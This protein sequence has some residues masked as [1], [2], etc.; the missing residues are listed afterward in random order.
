MGWGGGIGL[1]TSV[2][3]YLGIKLN[4]DLDN[5]VE[6]LICL[7]VNLLSKCTLFSV[8]CSCRMTEPESKREKMGFLYKDWQKNHCSEAA[9]Q[10]LCTR[11]TA[12]C[13]NSAMASG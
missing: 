11:S 6:Q 1:N 3:Y 8:P 9:S 7:L 2:M 12:Q 13:K 4:I 5:N 10:Q